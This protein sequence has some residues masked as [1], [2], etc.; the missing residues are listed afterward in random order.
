M[1]AIVVIKTA[2]DEVMTRQSD[3][4]LDINFFSVVL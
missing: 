3:M 2:D 4:A 1:M